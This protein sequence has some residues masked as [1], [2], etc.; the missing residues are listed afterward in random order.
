[1]LKHVS[2][3]EG[4]NKENTSIIGAISVILLLIQLINPEINPEKTY[5][6]TAYV[7]ANPANNLTAFQTMEA[8]T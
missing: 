2:K 6:K 5:E 8:T 7:I 1:M 4:K 3:F